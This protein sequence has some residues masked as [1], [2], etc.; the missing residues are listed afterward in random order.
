[1][2]EKFD[3]TLA[4][5]AASLR[6]NFG[7]VLTPV[8]KA[9]TLSGT[10]GAIFII[11]A[12]A[13]I[14]FRKTRKTRRAGI[15]AGVA[16]LYGLL[17]TNILLKNIVAR[18]RPYADETSVYFRFW[19]N[20]GSMKESGFSFPSGHSTASTAFAVALFIVF[21]KKY[22]WAFLFIPLIMGFTRIYFVVHY[23]SDVIGGFLAGTIAAIG[24][25][26]T[27]KAISKFER[28]KKFLS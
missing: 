5:F 23:A 6:E 25:Y 18:P 28:I 19:Q 27:V 16:L 15:T 3:Y 22:S 10:V 1:M 12:I 8:F 14:I 26:F 21:N 17:I 7:A 11:A 13:L 24:S 9:I 4:K 2:I 20:A